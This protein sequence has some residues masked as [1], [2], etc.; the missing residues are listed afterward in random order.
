MSSVVCRIYDYAVVPLSILSNWEKQ[1]ED[2][3]VPGALSSCV[4]YG[5]SRSMTPQQLKEYDI[6][7]TT[8]QTV[9]GEHDEKLDG[10]PK[11][12]KRKTQKNLFGVQWK[13][14]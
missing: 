6:V 10:E 7:I 9:T 3:V 11:S 8:Y 1:I 13:V 2:H 14:S 5:A 12:K 4:Y